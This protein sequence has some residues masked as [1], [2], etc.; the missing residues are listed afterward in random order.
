MRLTDGF[1]ICD[2]RMIAIDCL[3]DLSVDY[4]DAG[5]LPYFEK[6]DAHFVVA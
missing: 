4:F 2:L 5:L 6:T 3:I 1:R